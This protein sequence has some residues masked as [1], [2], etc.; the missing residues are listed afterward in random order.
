MDVFYKPKALERLR[1]KIE[2]VKGPG[3]K[4]LADSIAVV[5]A[6]GNEYDRVGGRDRYGRPVASL[7]APRKGEYAGKGGPPL[8]PSGA[9]SRVVANFRAV[10]RRRGGSWQIVAGWVGVLSAR[11]VPFLPFHDH[12]AGRLPTRA[13]FGI[14]PRTWA[15]VRDLVKGFKSKVKGVR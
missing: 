4:K 15:Q 7:K 3:S 6:A 13:I 2:F 14:S 8:A 1:K 12:G 10:A 9:S 11:G 5:V